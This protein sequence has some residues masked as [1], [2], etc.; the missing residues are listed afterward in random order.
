MNRNFLSARTLLI[1][2]ALFL[3]GVSAFVTSLILLPFLNLQIL[4]PFFLPVLIGLLVGVSSVGFYFSYPFLV[5]ASRRRKIDANLPTIANFMSVLAAS[6]MPLGSIIHSLARVGEEFH[7]NEETGRIIRD[8][9][10]MG[11]DTHTALKKASE[12]CASK[13]FAAL[14]DGVIATSHIGG[15]LSSYLR[16]QADKYKSMRMR[17]MKSF[18]DNLGIIAEVYTTFLVAAPLMLIVMLSV[19]SFIG[20]GVMVGNIDPKTLLNLLTFVIMPAGVGILILAVEIMAPL[21]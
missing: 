19:M 5:A 16:E 3:V 2:L 6:G 20:G 1:L 10:L 21:R 11:L 7:V 13:K 18:L 4:H 17:D 9:E 12:R 8:I 15:D 14:L